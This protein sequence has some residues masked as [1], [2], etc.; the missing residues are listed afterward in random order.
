MN[1]INRKRLFT[2]RKKTFFKIPFTKNNPTWKYTGSGIVYAHARNRNFQQLNK[3]VKIS[4]TYLGIGKV[5]F[6]IF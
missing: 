3:I 2:V 1:L 6:I 5:H 4:H